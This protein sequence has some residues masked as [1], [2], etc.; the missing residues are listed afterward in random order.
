M[1]FNQAVKMA[2]IN[3]RMNQSEFSARLG[4]SRVTLANW[5]KGKHTPDAMQVHKMCLIAG[6]DV[7]EFYDWADKPR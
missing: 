5:I 6:M 1:K 4:V 3:S 2:Q 7:A